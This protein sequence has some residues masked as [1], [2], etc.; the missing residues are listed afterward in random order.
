MFKCP[1]D[2]INWNYLQLRSH[3][4]F[5]IR[6]LKVPVNFDVGIACGLRV[7]FRGEVAFKF[8][9]VKCVC[10]SSVEMSLDVLFDA[11]LW[12]SMFELSFKLRITILARSVVLEYPLEMHCC[13]SV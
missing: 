11:F 1:L 13:K 2:L 5:E 7:Y 6:C 8:R 10:K 3:M 9:V 4:S 12:T